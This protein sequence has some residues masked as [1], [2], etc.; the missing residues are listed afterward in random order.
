MVTI[1]F[2]SIE[3]NLMIIWSGHLVSA[4]VNQFHDQ[5]HIYAGFIAY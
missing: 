5:I 1:I 2:P 3:P 4:S